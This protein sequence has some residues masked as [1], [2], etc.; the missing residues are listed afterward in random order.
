MT[1]A[2]LANIRLGWKG[3]LAG[4]T[5][6]YFILDKSD[7]AESFETWQQVSILTNLFSMSLAVLENKLDCL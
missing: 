1:T 4:N 3:L 2:Q 5:L 7:K 6:A